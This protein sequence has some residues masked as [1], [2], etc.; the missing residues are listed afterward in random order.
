MIDA[1]CYLSPQ[2]KRSHHLTAKSNIFTI[3]LFVTLQ[4]C[5][6]ILF[7]PSDVFLDGLHSNIRLMKWRCLSVWMWMDVCV[8]GWMCFH[9]KV[10]ILPYFFPYSS[11]WSQTWGHGRRTQAATTQVIYAPGVLP[12]LHIYAY[13]RIFFSKKKMLISTKKTLRCRGTPGQIFNF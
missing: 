1:N 12:H 4:P 5:I 3:I 6:N 7:M 10:N 8:D 2:L 11:F 9:K 13:L